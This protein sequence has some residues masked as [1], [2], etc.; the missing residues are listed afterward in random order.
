[1]VEQLQ[2]RTKALQFSG[3]VWNTITGAF[4]FVKTPRREDESWSK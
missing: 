3:N 1:M 2:H 4:Y